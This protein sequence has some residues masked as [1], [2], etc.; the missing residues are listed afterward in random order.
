MK[1]LK[2][3]GVFILSFILFFTLLT[4]YV[5][6]SISQVLSHEGITNVVKSMDLITILEDESGMGLEEAQKD[7]KKVKG[8][9]NYDVKAFV[10]SDEFAEVSADVISKL[11]EKGTLSQD[12]INE[13]VDENF[14][15]V[16]KA[17]KIKLSSKEK[18]EFKKN[19]KTTYYEQLSNSDSAGTIEFLSQVA[20][21]ETLNFLIITNLIIILLI[22]LIKG[23]KTNWYKGIRAVS[24][25]NLIVAL[26]VLGFVN[27]ILLTTTAEET[28]VLKNF[29]TA[30]LQ[31]FKS[32]AYI[33]ITVS[34][35][36]L[37]L[38]IVYSI[39]KKNQ[40]NQEETI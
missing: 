28:G 26:G 30:L 13:I 7:V 9:E 12:T 25:V 6:S 2:F 4:T 21:A 10:G 18:E 34:I 32:N 31:P 33:G 3:L 23:I 38:T 36:T 22:C 15:K 39:I 40:P 20:R 11:V 19:L 1:V 14:D 16:Y 27:T 5:V 8:F 17:A 24:I 37:I 29:G 35:L